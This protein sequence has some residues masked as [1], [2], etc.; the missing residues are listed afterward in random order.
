MSHVAYSP[1]N[2]PFDP[3]S[4]RFTPIR[5]TNRRCERKSHPH[6]GTRETW[7]APNVIGA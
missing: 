3:F 5:P 7:L 2:R 4:G 6:S 1:Q